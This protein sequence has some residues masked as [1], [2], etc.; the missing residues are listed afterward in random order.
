M[1]ST[2]V[3][4]LGEEQYYHIEDALVEKGYFRHEYV[5]PPRMAETDVTCCFCHKELSLYLSGNSHQITCKT[6]GCIDITV[7]GL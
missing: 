2:N 1:A 6:N 7:R 5:V 3:L 4:H